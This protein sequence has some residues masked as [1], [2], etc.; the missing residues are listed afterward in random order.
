MIKVR[1]AVVSALACADNRCE[2]LTDLVDEKGGGVGQE[3]ERSQDIP[4][5]A[6]SAE[7]PHRTRV[8]QDNEDAL[9]RSSRR[10]QL[11]LDDRTR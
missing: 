10:A 7:G 11:Y 2:R 5:S 6:S 8:T 9:S 1:T 3:E 4:S